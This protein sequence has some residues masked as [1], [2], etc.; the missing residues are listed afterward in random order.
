[1]RNRKANKMR[2][3]NINPAH[4]Q[5]ITTFEDNNTIFGTGMY[6]TQE[7]ARRAITRMGCTYEKPVLEAKASKAKKDSTV[8]WDAIA[9]LSG[10]SEM[11]VNQ[12]GEEVVSH[13]RFFNA[14]KVGKAINKGFE[15]KRTMDDGYTP[16][17]CEQLYVWAIAQVPNHKI[18]PV[19]V[20]TEVPAKAETPVTPVTPVTSVTPVIELPEVAEMS[21]HEQLIATVEK[22]SKW[23]AQVANEKAQVLGYTG[24]RPYRQLKRA[25]E[26]A[27]EGS[28]AKRE[29][30]L[31]RELCIR[32]ATA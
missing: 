21:P 17:M 3:V 22:A 5:F 1:M 8:D 15:T 12:H 11:K 31:A 4:G 6:R 30:G 26:G 14:F 2:K 24:K 18:A 23:N 16:E 25:H 29:L 28:Q 32:A 20:V 9:Q 7:G 10:H 19:E 27:I 13:A